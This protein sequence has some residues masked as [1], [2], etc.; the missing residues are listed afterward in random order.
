MT[1]ALTLNFIAVSYYLT[2]FCHNED[3]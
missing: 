2:M 1:K 3:D